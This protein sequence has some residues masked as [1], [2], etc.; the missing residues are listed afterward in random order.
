[1][2]ADFRAPQMQARKYIRFDSTQELQV[3]VMSAK[4]GDYRIIARARAPGRSSTRV[5]ARS[6]WP[7]HNAN[8]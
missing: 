5:L 3:R 2:S 8:A 6:A 7:R 1:M 4:R